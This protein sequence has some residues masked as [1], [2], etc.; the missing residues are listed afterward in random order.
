MVFIIINII[1]D[2]VPCNPISPGV[3]WFVVC[4]ILSYRN[5]FCAINLLSKA[6]MKSFMSLTVTSGPN[7]TPK[8]SDPLIYHQRLI[9]ILESSML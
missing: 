1:I 7:R 2:D 4:D 3:T 9:I 8:T 6:N 5:N